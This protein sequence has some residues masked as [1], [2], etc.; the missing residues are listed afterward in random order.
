MKRT[1]VCLLLAAAALLS[2]APAGRGPYPSTGSI[3]IKRKSARPV[4]T[5]L[6]LVPSFNTCSFYL[7][8]EE[9]AGLAVSFREKGTGTWQKGLSPVHIREEKLY[10]GSLVHLKED[11]A[12]EI[13]FTDRDGRTAASGE[14]RTWGAPLPVGKTVVLDSRNFRQHLTIS[15]K[16]TPEAWIKYTA[17][18][19]F[20]LKNDHTKALI[21]LK[22]ASCIILENL[23]LEGGG[24][25]AL[26][27][28]DSDHIRIINCDISGW[29][30]LGVQRFDRDG[31]YY[32]DKPDAKGRFRVVNYSAGIVLERGSNLVVERCYIHD[33]RNHANAWIYSHPAGP[34]A[35]FVVCP[36]S[37]V[38]RYNDFVGS[39]P[40]RWNDAVEG[41]YNFYEDGGFNRDAD[42]YGNFMI[43]CND[44]NIELDGGQQ[45]VRCFRNR[46]E[47]S[48]CGV[49]IQGNMAG[50]SYVFNN[51]FLNMG[52]E[53]GGAGQY[54]KTSTSGSGLSAETFIFNNSFY[55]R[56]TGIAMTKLLKIT[57]LN[58]VMS[59]STISRRENMNARGSVS[60]YNLC[61]NA[62]AGKDPDGLNGSPR[63]TDPEHGILTLAPDSPARGRGTEIPNFTGP[64][65]VDMGAFQ[66]A[67]PAELPYRPVPV[68][69]NAGKLN[70]QVKNGH[71]DVQK[72][73][74][75]VGGNN[76]RS[77]Y[78]IALNRAFDWLEVTPSSGV[79]RSG[80]RVEFSVKLHPEKMTERSM[81]RGAFLIRLENGFS[82]PV[83]VYAETEFRQKPR[84]ADP[85][86]FVCY[87]NA[88]APDG[89]PLLETFN[90]PE[91]DGGKALRMKKR[92]HP[93]SYSFEV[94][95]D[96]T[97][98]LLI[99]SRRGRGS[100]RVMAG[101][102]DGKMEVAYLTLRDL[103]G[104]SILAPGKGWGLKV[105]AYSLKAGRHT[106]K[107][108]P[109]NLLDL[110]LI[111][112]TE[113]PKPFE[114]R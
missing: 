111:A 17:A 41:Q 11:T 19:G 23:T 22:K 34:C 27:V 108:N 6:E 112:V 76:F 53:F 101:V 97:Y 54:I 16:G 37:T 102:D 78:R 43:F 109:L 9:I 114:P 89:E 49:S 63:Y 40:H 83:S 1:T 59:G 113:D 29:G 67:D 7:A 65:P 20:V 60:N 48:Y 32:F 25:N 88:E 46:F 75:S 4:R 30:S 8:G 96:G 44:D 31:K 91:A 77:N 82:R 10:R 24:H 106:L 81:Y 50:P 36:V 45:N 47:G 61:E 98:Y 69:V 42:I 55:G 79:F 35:V 68:S 110:D 28:I 52:D 94:P 70:F 104:Y 72:I 84:P 73:A 51:L 85:Q 58:N 26:E 71:A 38:L 80:D 93:Y 86:T 13:R 12:Y 18:P 90:D 99:R 62:H 15:E 2:A 95:R 3:T 107:L 57:A 56:G 21:T 100:H 87:R 39:D 64:A 5:G 66:S 33:P 14:F 105:H 92:N 74:V 103:W